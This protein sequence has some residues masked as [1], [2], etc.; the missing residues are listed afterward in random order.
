MASQWLVAAVLV[1]AALHRPAAVH[2][3]APATASPTVQD[4]LDAFFAEFAGK[5]DGI[6]ALTARFHQENVTPDETSPSSGSIVYAKPRRIVFRY[7]DPQET[8]LIDG[9]RVY[10]YDAGYEQVQIFDLEDDPQAE[11]LFLGFDQDA[12]RLKRA[13]TVSL[14][15]PEKPNCGSRGLE[16]APKKKEQTSDAHDETPLFNRVWLTLRDADFLPCYIHVF[17]DDESEVRIEVSDVQVQSNLD[18]ALTQLNLPEG[19]RIIENEKLVE[20]VGPGGKRIPEPVLPTTPPPAAPPRPDE[21][22]P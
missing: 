7:D 3:D 11:A 2:A 17:N 16:L 15:D 12:K 4:N 22:K 20:T 5:R 19:T 21:K 1:A 6:A 8:Y 13:Y 14:S 9:L 18:P 10:H